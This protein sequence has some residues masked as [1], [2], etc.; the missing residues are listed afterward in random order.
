[1]IFV[2]ELKNAFPLTLKCH[3]SPGVIPL[4]RTS[5][6]GTGAC[7]SVMVRNPVCVVNETL[8]ADGDE[9]KCNVVVMLYSLG[10]PRLRGNHR[11]GTPSGIVNVA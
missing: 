11:S 5:C 8:S 1:M 2:P 9:E 7:T 10:V 3:W 6:S 4:S